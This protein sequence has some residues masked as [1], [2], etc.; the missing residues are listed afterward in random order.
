M[1]HDPSDYPSWPRL[2]EPISGQMALWLTN[3]Q[4]VKNDM[5]MYS[6][7]TKKLTRGQGDTLSK[8][9]QESTVT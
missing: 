2:G 1:V 4:T 7:T 9:T 3:K 8:M 5:K 6:Y